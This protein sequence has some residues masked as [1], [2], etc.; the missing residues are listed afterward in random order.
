VQSKVGQ[1]RRCTSL[2][3]SKPGGVDIR[4]MYDLPSELR[5]YDRG[6]DFSEDPNPRL[7]VHDV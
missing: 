6:E 4:T 7:L 5:A 2:V 3:T 1:V